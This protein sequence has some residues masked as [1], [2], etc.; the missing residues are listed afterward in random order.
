MLFKNRVVTEKG[1]CFKIYNEAV[2]QV[3]K[4]KILGIISDCTLTWK[5]HIS[6]ISG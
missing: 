5:E 3:K 1:M 6:Y 2:T 4:T